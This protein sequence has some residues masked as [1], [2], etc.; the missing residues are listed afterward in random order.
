M[1]SIN[2]SSVSNF[3]VKQM[4]YRNHSLHRLKEEWITRQ[5]QWWLVCQLSRWFFSKHAKNLFFIHLIECW[6]CHCSWIFCKCCYFVSRSPV[7]AELDKKQGEAASCIADPQQQHQA[8]PDVTSNS[9]GDASESPRAATQDTFVAVNG[10]SHGSA[11]APPDESNTS[12]SIGVTVSCNESREVQ[13][14]D[15]SSTVHSSAVTHN[16]V[17]VV[18]SV[19][20][21]WILDNV[22]SVWMW[23]LWVVWFHALW[24]LRNLSMFIK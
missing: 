4:L 7:D 22:N 17:I 8:V 12:T 1:Q 9:D 19:E 13:L 2:I 24:Y 16:V 21:L 18:D 14:C 11:E 5:N 6:S 3:Y 20:V 10:T 23:I 15:D